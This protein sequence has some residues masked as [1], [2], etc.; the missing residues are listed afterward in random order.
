MA[1]ALAL[2]GGQR[3]PAAVSPPPAAPPEAPPQASSPSEASAPTTAP[4]VATPAPPTRK[5]P[6]A[7][8]KTQ[9]TISRREVA[10]ETVSQPQAMGRLTLVTVPWSEVYLGDR[11]L[12]TTPLFE[13]ELP[14]GA[15]RLRAVNAS[16]QIDRILEVVIR[17]SQTTK[18]K[19]VF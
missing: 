9:K 2:H 15:H 17:P 1:L 11:L 10:T 12:G 6:K 8:L 18:R 14:A 16:E 3:A 4:L 13:V 19:E 7:L 5:M